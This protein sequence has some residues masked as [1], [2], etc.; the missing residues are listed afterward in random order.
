MKPITVAITGMNANPENPGPGVGVA[1]AILEE[2]PNIKVIGLSYDALDAGFYLPNLCQRG[3]LLPYPS[4]GKKPYLKRLLEIHE[5]ESYDYIIPCLDSE[6]ALFISMKPQ[7]LDLGVKFL[8]PSKE[9]L[10]KI[11]KD[12][13]YE[14]CKQIGVKV[15][16]TKKITNIGFFSEIS[17]VKSD[18]KFPLFVK[19]IFHESIL[20]Y[21]TFEAEKA[22]IK[23]S[24]K[25]GL[26]ILVQEAI[27]G[28]EVLLSGI[29]N[30]D[31]QLISPTMIAKKNTTS[32]GKAI[33]GICVHDESLL[34]LSKTIVKNFHWTGPLEVECIRDENDNL[35]LIEVNP[36]F[37]AWIYF[38]KGLDNNLPY[39]LLSYLHS[40][41]I[42]TANPE[43]SQIG[44]MFI[45]YPVEQVVSQEEFESLAIFGK[46][47]R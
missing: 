33:A 21:N 41:T 28:K 36:R 6:I 11:N 45:R 25:W 39:K 46:T 7:L 43:K 13:L 34:E 40:G 16:H 14:N 32:T 42:S 44:K 1:K 47:K 31:H 10:L 4:L 8:I 17:S 5:L 22:F 18:I 19:G 20:C 29:A 3:Y 9:A 12:R 38:S 24:A 2:D 15:P 23:I 37:P 27:K 30:N 35:Y 26:P